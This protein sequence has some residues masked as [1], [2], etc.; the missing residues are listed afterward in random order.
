V[1]V[2]TADG[3]TRLEI[4]N[5][6]ANNQHALAIGG[7]DVGGDAGEPIDLAF[8]VNVV[9]GDGDMAVGLIGITL[10]PEPLV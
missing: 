7:F 9:D 1:F 8:D 4:T 3:F 2:S 5:V 6:D 10:N